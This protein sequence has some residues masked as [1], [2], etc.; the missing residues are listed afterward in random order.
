MGT[1]Y[2]GRRRFNFYRFLLKNSLEP[3]KPSVFIS[4]IQ[5]EA[6]A[7]IDLINT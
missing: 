1:K 7:T 2:F 3:A 4:L 5:S 6:S